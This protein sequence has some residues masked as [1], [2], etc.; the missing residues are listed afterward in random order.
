MNAKQV[1]ENK[2]AILTLQVDN[3]GGL[4]LTFSKF[5]SV[6]NAFYPQ[7][8]TPSANSLCWPFSCGQGG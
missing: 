6:Q 1:D 2:Y 4:T 5:T 3:R 7:Q 8:I